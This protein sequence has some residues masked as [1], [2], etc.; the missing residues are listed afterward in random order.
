MY[1]FNLIYPGNQSTHNKYSFYIL[2]LV[3][4]EGRL[5][6]NMTHL[7]PVNYLSKIFLDGI[8]TKMSLLEMFKYYLF[9]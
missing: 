5:L 8:R 1:L 7:Q 9:N 6:W 2:C 4:L 3:I